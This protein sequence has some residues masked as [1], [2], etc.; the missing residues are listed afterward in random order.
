MSDNQNEQ[1]KSSVQPSLQ[2]VFIRGTLLGRQAARTFTR[3]GTT[4]EVY[5]KPRIGLMVDGTE[6]SVKAQDDEHANGVLAGKVRGD[7]VT[8]RVEV[9]APFGSSKPPE[10]TLPGVVQRR[11]QWV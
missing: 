2:G 8:L 6:V 3:A 1:A 4:E 5:V 9:V 7:E 11:D 10:F